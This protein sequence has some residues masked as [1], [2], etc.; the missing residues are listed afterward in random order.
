MR[1]ILRKLL[2]LPMLAAPLGAL[3][4]PLYSLTFLPQHFYA[5]G[6]N[7]AGHIVGTAGAGAAIWT[8]TAVTYLG[9][10][11]PGSEGLAINNHD[12]IAGRVGMHGF[13]YS[14]GVVQDV[15]SGPYRNWVTGLNDAGR[16]TGT[17]RDMDGAQARGLIWVTDILTPIGPFHS[18]MDFAN[19]I[20]NPGQVAGFTASPTADF[21]NPERTAFLYDLFDGVT[22]LGTLGGHV[23]EANDL[24]DSRQVVGWSETSVANEERPFLYVDAAG[25]MQDLGSLG[26]RSGRAN[27]INN[28]GMVVG[29]SDVGDSTGFDYHA[30]LFANNHMVDLNTLIDPASGWRLVSATD[31]N[32]AGQI[33]GTACQGTDCRAV[34]LDMIPGVPEPGAW[35]MLLIGLGLIAY[36]KCRLRSTPRF[37]RV[38]KLLMLPLLAGPLAAMAEPIYTVTALPADFSASNM[39]NSGSIVGTMGAAAAVWTSSGITD[40]GTLAPESFGYGINNRG[41]IAG[42]WQ[43]DAFVYSGGALRNIGRLGT[44]GT[45]TARGANDAGQVIGNGF[46]EV[47]ERQRGFVYTGGVIRIIPTLGGEWSYAAAINSSG[48]VAGIATI[49]SADFIN[50][51]RHAIMY[52]DRVM[53][54]LGSL[55]GVVSEAYDINDAGQAVGM[56]QT[57]PDDRY[58]PSHAFLYEGGAMIDLGFLGGANARANGINNAG[59][60]VGWSELGGEAPPTHAFLYANHAMVDLNALIDPASGWEIMS[61]IDIND[62]RQILATACR[63]GECTTVRMDLINAV[64]EPR[65]WGML[66]AGM[67]LLGGLRRGR[68]PSVR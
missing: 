43:G 7:N 54:D 2:L 24:N 58:S 34:R 11:A 48:Q 55:G 12:A 42:T 1:N 16:A 9:A 39:N 36:R 21:G 3:A 31:I 17:V 52:Q 64:P 44:W 23:S 15:D 18:Y 27:G 10:L 22:L 56:S 37:A 51:T 67:L 49:D 30:F 68:R 5:S 19:A 41:D 50:P 65:A 20:N 13:V 25:G 62:A 61:A 45:S 38:P 47:G 60:V 57:S 63:L 66:L 53:H 35:L 40:I 28:G 29:V 46:Y 33:L 59:L 26:G 6:I 4:D 32:D 8:D 14:G